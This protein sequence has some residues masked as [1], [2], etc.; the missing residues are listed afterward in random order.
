MV[1]VDMDLYL[2]GACKFTKRTEPLGVFGIYNDQ[3]GYTL[4]VY[5]SDFFDLKRFKSPDELSD[6]PLLRAREDRIAS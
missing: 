2:S 6:L 3:T 5:L 1:V 4:K